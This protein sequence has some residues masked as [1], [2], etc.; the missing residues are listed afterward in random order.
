MSYYQQN[1]T[2]G[3]Y[4]ARSGTQSRFGGQ[5]NFRDGGSQQRGNDGSG[6]RSNSYQGGNGGSGGFR[7]SSYGGNSGYGNQGGLKKVE[8]GNKS[9]R[10]HTKHFYVPHAAIVE[11]SEFEVDQYRKSKEIVIEGDAP[12]PIQ[13]F[14]EANFPEYIM[15]EIFKQG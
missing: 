10:P 14:D 5:R 6:Y 8:W 11:R 7:S 13:N 4:Q 1:S 3:S 15:E 9:L 12:K 2:G